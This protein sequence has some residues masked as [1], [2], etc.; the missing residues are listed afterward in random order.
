MS[1]PLDSAYAGL[2]RRLS[3]SAEHMAKVADTLETRRCT[4]AVIVL[5][6]GAE[7]VWNVGPR[8]AMVREVNRLRRNGMTARLSTLGAA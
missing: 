4:H 1:H 2:P 5:F 6:D 3:V 7:E 8:V